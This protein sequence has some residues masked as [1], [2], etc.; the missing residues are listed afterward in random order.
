MLGFGL[1]SAT[2]GVAV[3]PSILRLLG[4][5]DATT[6]L[7]MDYLRPS[8]F[9]AAFYYINI[10]LTGVLRGVGNTSLPFKV[11]LGSNL[12]NGI[13]N[14][15]FILGG[16]GLPAY[17][18]AGAAYGTILSNAWAIAM[19]YWLINRGAVRGLSIP[20]S[21]APIDRRLIAKL[22]KI[23][24]PAALDMT[25]LNVMLMSIVGMVGHLDELAVAAHGI[26]LRIQSLAFVP[27]L[28][29]SQA[30]GAMVGQA[31]G[32]ND[33]DEAREVLRLTR[34]LAAA[35]MCGLGALIVLF[36]SQIVD[37]GFNVSAG[38]PTH[39]Y[40]MQWMYVLGGSFPVIGAWL[41]YSGL[42]SGAGA[43]FPSLRINATTTV[44]VQVP[45]SAL[46][47]LVFGLGP[48]GVWLGF[49]AG[50]VLK[51]ILGHRAFKKG[52]WA[53]EAGTA[54]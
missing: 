40:T 44:L 31:L 11:A 39:G 23:G 38:T 5:S 28:A 41:A 26:G 51:V 33:P 46:L 17:G 42:L 54:R 34:K 30:A 15:G 24:Y 6:D 3:A 35:V 14:Y 9:G 21:F 29:I 52:D 53:G 13:L 32:R 27:G 8:L 19:L 18:V 37:Y 25:V 16:L 36:G 43:T 12:L 48:I 10:L 45:T 1:L 7:A 20:L 4:A 47:G 22:W 49:P 2:V 50:E